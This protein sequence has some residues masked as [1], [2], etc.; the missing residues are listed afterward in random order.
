MDQLAK[1]AV[2]VSE[3]V[4]DLLL[5]SLLD[6]DGAEGLVAAL[7]GPGG[8]GEEVAAAGVVIHRHALDVSFFPVGIR[9]SAQFM[10]E[11][12]PGTRVGRGRWRPA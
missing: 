3:L 5:G 7:Q 12:V 2:S 10:R 8:V 9:T 1:G 11:P 4:G 6:E